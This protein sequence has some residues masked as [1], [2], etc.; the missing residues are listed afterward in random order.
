[1][2]N[3]HQITYLEG[4]SKEVWATDVRFEPQHI[5]FYDGDTFVL[6]V[7]ADTVDKVEVL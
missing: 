6:A 7:R 1:M 5:S 4:G 2:M 3:L